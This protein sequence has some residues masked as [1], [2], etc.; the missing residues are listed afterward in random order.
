MPEE[1]TMPTQPPR[2]GADISQSLLKE[3]QALAKASSERRHAMIRWTIRVGAWVAAIIAIVNVFLFFQTR[4]WQ[5]LVVVGGEALAVACLIRANRLDRWGMSD[6]AIH[7]AIFSLALAFG[8]GELVYVG[9]TLYLAVAGVLTMSVVG[10]LILPR[11]WEIWGGTAG[12]FVVYLWL[13]N[14]FK[15]L[16]R[17]HIA[18]ASVLRIFMPALAVFSTLAALWLVV[19]AF[20]TGT[21]RARLLIAF[22]SMVLLPAIAVSTG[23]VVMGL[24]SGRR[25]A[26]EQLELAA[27]FKEAESNAWADSLQ[28]GLNAAL[29]EA[30]AILLARVMGELRLD[31]A[32]TEA[33]AVLLAQA[34]G[35]L[36][37]NIFTSLENHLRQY[38]GQAQL[39]EE[40]FLL[41]L[42]GQ[43]VASTDEA[44][45]GKVHSDQVYF[46]EGLKGPYVSFYFPSSNQLVMVAAQ[47]VIDEGGQTI[48]VFAGYASTDAL[49]EIMWER[50]G[51][52]ETGK[53]YLVSADHALL[54]VSRFGEKEGSEI[55]TQG[56][57]AAIENRADGSGF[58][59]DYRGIPV[60]GVFH[61]LPKLQV[62]LLAER[63]QAEIFGAIYVT[64]GINVGIALASALIAV[65][66]SLFITRSI[67]NPL[68]DLAETATEIAAGDLERVAK[69]GREDEIG[70]LGRAFNSMT[71][72]LR[73][74]IGSL[75]QRIF[76]R[77]ITL[78]RRT[79]YLEAAAEVSRAASSILEADELIRQV[80]ELIREKFD[81]YYVGLLL[82]DE[83]REWAV[84]QA[85]TGEAGQAMLT[86]GHRIRIGEGMIG[87]SIANAQARVAPE[88]GEDAVRLATAELPDTRSEATI[89]LRSRGQVLGALTVQSTQPNAFRPGFV[90]VLQTM[91]DEVAVAIHNARLFAESQTA[92]ETVRRAYGEFSRQVQAELIHARPNLSFCSSERGITSTEKTWR[93]ETE[94]AFRE[95][96]TVRGDGA[97]AGAG[98]P[99]AVPI[100]VRGD[101][102]G[103]LDTYKPN[104]AGDWTTEEVDLLERLVEQ[105]ELALEGAWLYEATQR[106]AQ[107]EQLSRQ[108]TERVRATL[109]VET[110]ARTAA[111]ELAK[112]LGSAR[113]FVKLGRRTM[114]DDDTKS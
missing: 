41:N 84:L 67:A 87:W 21:I 81:L 75:E 4:A 27:A 77:T 58:Y 114:A 80:V 25:Q 73:D 104:E 9:A 31:A 100:R 40:L 107:Y 62:A 65:V 30:D 1:V 78:E 36:R 34:I 12:L 46:Q 44:H 13:V 48:G 103:V 98:R 39:F 93:P 43:T 16:P 85:G 7:W 101:V 66:A 74:L 29:T 99:L 53:I 59:K 38:N 79:R 68:A 19:R 3:R 52:G 95:G 56:A 10:A 63:D 18:Q 108:I 17:Y 83:S 20:R 24:Q 23:S 76:A 47:P 14:R 35:E 45:R 106:R 49:N 6:A 5:M 102:V 22:V 86:R 92:L 94:R 28:T 82:R 32:L 70:T 89:P 110:I 72:Q 54:T 61:W 50:T 71:A 33:D 105:L 96:R 26:I 97:D 91:A 42:K 88:V 51:V 69:V 90:A 60:A 11:K 64:L 2:Q 111:E 15:P 55:R 109:D 57:D 112:A 37:T 113:G 8:S